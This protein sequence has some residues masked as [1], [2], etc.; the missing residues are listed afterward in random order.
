[1]NPDSIENTVLTAGTQ[2][3]GPFF[4]RVNSKKH[5]KGD[6]IIIRIG[7]GTDA[8]SADWWVSSVLRLDYFDP[9]SYAEEVARYLRL[10]MGLQ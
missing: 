5:K 8:K 7:H 4:V 3:F 10:K 1:M 9:S 2:A 6:K